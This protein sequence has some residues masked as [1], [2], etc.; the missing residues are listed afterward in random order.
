MLINDFTLESLGQLVDEALAE[1]QAEVAERDEAIAILERTS[2]LRGERLREMAS[3]ECQLSNALV[4]QKDQILGLANVGHYE[5]ALDLLDFVAES[6]QAA[7]YDY[8][9]CEIRQRVLEEVRRALWDLDGSKRRKERA[10][11]EAVE[12]RLGYGPRTEVAR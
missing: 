7:S 5:L 1:A 10:R 11:L 8:K 12:A 3:R 4:R 2:A 9:R 6:W